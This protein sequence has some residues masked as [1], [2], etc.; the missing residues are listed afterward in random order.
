MIATVTEVRAIP[1]I[2]HD[3][4]MAIA[5]VA[6]KRLL[7][8]VDQLSEADWSRPTDCEGWDVKALLSHVLGLMEASARPVEFVRQFRRASKAAKASGRPM[9]D[10]MTASQVRD[11][12][13]L[14]PGQMTAELQKLA[15]MAVQGRRRTPAVLRAVPIKPGAPFEGTWKLGYLLDI[16]ENRDTWMH[17]VDLTRATGKEMVLT[18]DHDGRIVADIVAEW[19]RAHQQPF[20]LTLEG[21]AGGVFSQ[22]EAGETLIL[23]AIEFCRILSGRGHGSGLL[24]REV[25]F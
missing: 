2:G 15:P 1:E 22:G 16:I 17:R 14:S 24:S 23:D 10:E 6:A 11:H 13:Q 18:P 21:P 4:A 25:P 5:E 7:D 8:V 12:A 3:E 19:G 20:T 9:V